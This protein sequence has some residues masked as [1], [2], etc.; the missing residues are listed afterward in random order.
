MCILVYLFNTGLVGQRVQGGR[1]AVHMKNPS[2]MKFQRG[3]GAPEFITR[4]HQP[5]SR[6]WRNK[7][8]M[9]FLTGGLKMALLDQLA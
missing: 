5:S 6:L 3:R 7:E 8:V 9:S 1:G 2:E 4:L